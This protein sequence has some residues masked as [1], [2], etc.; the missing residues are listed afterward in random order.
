[1]NVR[2]LRRK[3]R[4]ESL[5]N[6]TYLMAQIIGVFLAANRFFWT[7]YGF[8]SLN[9]LKVFGMIMAVVFYVLWAISR[10]QLGSSFSYLPIASS[11]ITHGLYSKFSHPIY[12]FSS[13]SLFGYLI[14]LGNLY[15]FLVFLI[16]IPIQIYRSRQESHA[17]LKEFGDEY[18]DH[19]K[20]LW[21]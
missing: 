17:L 18:E 2:S 5:L 6:T 15:Y 11:L 13:L 9:M 1:M 3:K 16:I 8:H 20:Q 14:L 7:S 10:L 21:V 19:V 12:I 4:W